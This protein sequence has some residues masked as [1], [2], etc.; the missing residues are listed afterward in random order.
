MKFYIN[1]IGSN[2]DGL[3]NLPY[4]QKQ[5]VGLFSQCQVHEDGYFGG[6]YS[7]TKYIN[8]TLYAV[9]IF[10]NGCYKNAKKLSAPIKLDRF[11]NEI[12]TDPHMWTSVIEADT[13]DDAISQFEKSHLR[14]WKSEIDEH[15]ADNSLVM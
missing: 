13:I 8:T 6:Y 14:D 12:Q 9:L 4:N 7:S 1:S 2:L 3:N 5:Y 10:E 15:S 11:Y